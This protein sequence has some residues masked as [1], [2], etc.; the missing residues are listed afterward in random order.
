MR[1]QRR[2]RGDGVRRVAD[3]RVGDAG[4]P[5]R[6]D[7]RGRLELHRPAGSGVVRTAVCVETAVVGLDVPDAREDLPLQ[8]EALTRLLVEDEIGGRDA[9]D[10]RR[11]RDHLFGGDGAGARED[12]DPAAQDDE[13]DQRPGAA[14]QAAEAKPAG[15]GRSGGSNLWLSW[16]SRSDGRLVSAAYSRRLTTAS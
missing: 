8:P 13:C 6:F 11:R 10:R 2:G 12:P 14:D 15:H 3:V 9:T 16:S 4:E 7:E 1:Q 5:G